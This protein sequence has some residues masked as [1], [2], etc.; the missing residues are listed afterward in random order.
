MDLDTAISYLSHGN[1]TLLSKDNSK[2]KNEMLYENKQIAVSAW[3]G[4]E[5]WFD[6]LPLCVYILWFEKFTFFYELLPNT[7]N[8]S[9]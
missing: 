3:I 2:K 7:S 4:D 5:L 6:T 1:L 9:A 8:V